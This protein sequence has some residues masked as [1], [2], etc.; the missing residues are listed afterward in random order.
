MIDEKNIIITGHN[1]CKTKI[2][3]IHS[4]ISS[5]CGASSLSVAYFNHEPVVRL[6][7]LQTIDSV[8]NSK[9]LP[10]TVITVMPPLTNCLLDDNTYGVWDNSRLRFM[11]PDI[12][13][14]PS[15]KKAMITDHI[16][17]KYDISIE[18]TVFYSYVALD[19]LD[20]MMDSSGIQF[21]FTFDDEYSSTATAKLPRFTSFVPYSSLVER[22]SSGNNMGN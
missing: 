4:M 6:I 2:D 7:A 18:M 15:S 3:E 19:I 17:R 1:S 21:I 8:A 5:H 16:N 13:G 10:S 22:I 11:L 14:K 12:N 9:I 20:N